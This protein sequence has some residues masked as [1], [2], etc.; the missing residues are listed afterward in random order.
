MPD[1]H[2][3]NYKTLLEEVQEGLSSGRT[4]RD[5]GLE[6]TLG[7]TAIPPKRSTDSRALASK[8]PGVFFPFVEINKLL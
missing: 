6:D 5:S 7:E 2:T 8:F 3:E 1:F 4:D